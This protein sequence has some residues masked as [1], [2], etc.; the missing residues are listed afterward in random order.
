[1]DS[2]KNKKKSKKQMIYE[3]LLKSDNP[4]SCHEFIRYG[5]PINDHSAN[6]RINELIRINKIDI[7]S[8]VREGNDFKEYW[9]EKEKGQLSFN[10]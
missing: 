1:M 8:R 5:I 3:L 2:I 10:L 9:I 7:K 4:I 6:A